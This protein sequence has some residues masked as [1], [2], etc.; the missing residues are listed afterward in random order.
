MTEFARPIS[1]AGHHL[2]SGDHCRRHTCAQCNIKNVLQAATGTRFELGQPGGPYVVIQDHW[3]ANCLCHDL[4]QVQS[5]PA[6][7]RGVHGDPLLRV[8]DTGHHE[9]YCADPAGLRYARSQLGDDVNRRP[10]DCVR[11]EVSGRWPLTAT[12]FE[13]L[14]IKQSRLNGGAADIDSNDQIA[15]IRKA[16]PTGTDVAARLG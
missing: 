13:P 12:V 15:H 3:Q 14:R 8:Y 6:D 11:A 2:A 5:A 9:A 16:G 7:V 10:D 4:A 1:G